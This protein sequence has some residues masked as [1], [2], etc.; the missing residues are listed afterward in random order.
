MRGLI[1]HELGEPE[2]LR[3]EEIPAPNQGPVASVSPT[4]SR[5]VLFLLQ[6]LELRVA[7]EHA[8]H[9]LEVLR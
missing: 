4:I 1:L 9:H 2:N 6:Q 8:L 3:L 5:Q 7:L